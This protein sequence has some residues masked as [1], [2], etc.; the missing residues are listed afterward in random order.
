MRLQR[1]II[2]K[3]NLAI[4]HS[5][6]DVKVYLFGSRVDDSKK[7]GDID[8]AIDN[9]LPREEFRKMKAKF[10]ANMT[11][12]GFELKI[13]V[14]DYNTKDELLRSEILRNSQLLR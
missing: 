3:I 8:I 10:L 11:K 12:A 2:E 4:K 1:N 13:D 7:G 14:V 9:H 6:G 5:F